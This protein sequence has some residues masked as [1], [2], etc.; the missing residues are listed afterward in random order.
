MIPLLIYILKVVLCSAIFF[1]YYFL[2]LRNRQFHHWNRFYI[3]S[4][5]ILSLIIPFIQISILQYGHDTENQPVR[6]LKVV[7][8]AN[9]YLDNI[10]ITG[11]MHSSPNAWYFAAY[12]TVSI[13]LLI[14]FLRSL[15]KVIRLIK[16]HQ[17]R[18]LHKIRFVN[19]KVPE[20]PFSFFRYIFWNERIELDSETGQRIFQHEI[21]HVLEMHT[22]DKIF[23]QC[24]LIIFWCNPFFW[25]Y[26]KELR[27]IHEFI[28]D[29]KAVGNYGAQAFATMILQASFPGQYHTMINPFFNSSIKRRLAMLNNIHHPRISYI[30][31]I[32]IL[33]LMAF[34]FF[35]FTLKTNKIFYS[36]NALTKEVTVVIDAG[37]GVENGNRTGARHDDLF[38][39]D[40]VLSLAK[41]INA[42]NNDPYLKIVLT[43]NGDEIIDLRKRTEIAN[44]NQADLFISL[45]L[46]ANTTNAIPANGSN[47]N[48]FEVYV[49]NTDTKYIKQ[50]EVFGSILK[51]QLSSLYN[52]NPEFIKLQSGV[53]VLNHNFCPSVLVECGFITDEHDRNYITQEKNQNA[54]AGKVLE[55]IKQYFNSAQ[56]ITGSANR[57]DKKT[58][59]ETVTKKVYFDNRKN[60]A[61]MASN[62]NF[63]TDQSKMDI[64]STRS[65]LIINNKKY[66]PAS[67]LR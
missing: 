49:S 26:R 32:L 8:A 29:R 33:P 50:S 17:I 19:T 31:R 27:L 16:T 67:T 64:D 66:D 28:A 22:L 35:A 2:A 40:I 12:I 58:G 14:A 44:E 11:K 56:S 43:R 57:T 25:L 38:E 23:M 6:I 65:L 53:W 51:Q 20:A 52:T 18:Q 55:S 5:T 34:V 41:K 4:A 30:G 24:I 3:L 9:D 62:I 1:L 54:F 37:H 47:G 39:D 45:H 13:I 36:G 48:G 42:I 59:T 61:V 21:V 60:I 10:T 7:R 15:S 63:T 46:N